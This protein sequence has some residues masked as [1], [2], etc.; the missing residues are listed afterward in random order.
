MIRAHRFCAVI[1]LLLGGTTA[2]QESALERAR[3]EAASLRQSSVDDPHAWHCS[4]LHDALRGW[5]ESVL[6][7]SKATL[8]AQFDALQLKI[9]AALRRAGLA[10]A[11]GGPAS[12]DPGFVAVALSRPPEDTDKLVVKVEV[13]IPCGSNDAVYIYDYGSGAP[14]RVLESRSGERHDES[15]L[16]VRVSKKDALGNQLILTARDGVQCFSTFNKLSYELFRLSPRANRAESILSGEHGL[17]LGDYHPAKVRLEPGE[18]LMEMG[19]RSIDSGILVRP[20]VLHFQAKA[21][22]PVQR[23]DPV[24]LLP[25][26]FVDEWMTRPWQEMESRSDEA[27]RSKLE[28]WHQFLGGGFVAGDYTLVQ[29]CQF[30][31]GQWQIAVDLSFLKGEALPEPLTVF[32]LVQQI[33]QYRFRMMGISFD[34]QDGCPGESELNRTTSPTLFP[35]VKP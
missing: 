33:E 17:R 3:S 35:A 27:G 26:D 25:E 23:I 29:P 15:L 5:F 21:D 6:P 16:D 28:Q 13:D 34:R 18:A 31:I 32:F 19:D 9:D 4:G 7:E 10:P 1:I 12:A 30:V 2:A 14:R 20:H 11:N 8:D 24:A 22:S